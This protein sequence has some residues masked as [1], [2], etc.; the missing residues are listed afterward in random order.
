MP[1]DDDA[2]FLSKFSEAIVNYKACFA[3]ES[4]LTGDW[5]A[6]AVAA[7]K[8]TG[9]SKWM[10]TPDK[11]SLDPISLTVDDETTT[12]SY[13]ICTAAYPLGTRAARRTRTAAH[14]SS[15]RG[16]QVGSRGVA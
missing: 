4:N 15:P 1:A 10:V 13:T 11:D 6:L 7:G 12:A 8:G 2:V 14:P 16:A 9:T 5:S 3:A